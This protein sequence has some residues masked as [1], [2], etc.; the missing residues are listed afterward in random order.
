MRIIPCLEME[1]PWP[2]SDPAIPWPEIRQLI[3]IRMLQNDA[4]KFEMKGF[5]INSFIVVEPNDNAHLVEQEIVSVLRNRAV[6]NIAILLLGTGC[7][8]NEILSA[9]KT[10]ISIES[11]SLKIAAINAKAG[12]V[13]SVPLNSA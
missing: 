5:L 6:C 9:K 10:D 7:R 2:V 12:R 11:K 3:Q 1:I 4:N 13:R 8:L